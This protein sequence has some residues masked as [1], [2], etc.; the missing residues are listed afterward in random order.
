MT[1]IGSPSRLNEVD[2]SPAPTPASDR[3]Y[4][5]VLRP[6]LELFDAKVSINHWQLRDCIKPCSTAKSSL[7][8]IH[9]HSIRSLNTDPA[10][11][12][13]IPAGSSPIHSSATPSIGGRTRVSKYAHGCL[14]H[15]QFKVA[16][17]EETLGDP[18]RCVAEFNFKPRCFAEHNGLFACG[19]LVGSD[20]RG[21]PT[22][23]N[24]YSAVPGGAPSTEPPAQPI[25]MESRELLADD[26]NYSNP[27]IWKGILSLYNANTGFK[28]SLVL[29]QFINNCVT[30]HP[31]SAHA[32]NLY[33]CNNDGHIYQCDVSNRDVALVKRYSDLKFPLNNACLS[34]DGK[35]LIVSGDSNKFAIYRQNEVVNQFSLNYDNQPEWGGGSSGRRG[36]VR[37]VTRFDTD[38]STAR[39][40][41]NVFESSNGDHGFYSAFSQN[42]QQFATLFQNGVCL[43]YDIRNTTNPLAEIASSRAQSHNG[44]F[45]VCKFSH[46]VDDLLIISEHQGR[47]HVVDTRN[48]ANH[49]VIFLPNKVVKEP[50][51]P[52]T[53]SPSRPP[54][55]NT[56]NSISRPRG[57]YFYMMDDPLTTPGPPP[58]QSTRNITRPFSNSSRS[59][60]NNQYDYA[61]GDPYITI[62]RRV[63]MKYLQPRVLPYP[64][65]V[66]K[67]SNHFL[68]HPH[69]RNRQ[70]GSVSSVD[71]TA[72]DQNSNSASTTS[73]TKEEENEF[74]SEPYEVRRIS[75]SS[76]IGDNTP[77]MTSGVDS[78][79]TRAQSAWEREVSSRPSSQPF[80]LEE[81][82]SDDDE[83]DDTYAQLSEVGQRLDPTNIVEN[84]LPSTFRPFRTAH[85]RGNTNEILGRHTNNCL[86]EENNISG[87]SW[88]NDSE[89]SSLIVGTDY[90][91]MKWN[92]DTYSRRS[93]ASFDF[94]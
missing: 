82:L 31:R 57:S 85:F 4:Q 29:G 9:D 23:W 83:F 55:V 58:G 69:H 38:D 71:L 45:R 61:R 47:V 72:V 33:A 37:I 49:Q 67:L 43:M 17:T 35:T 6:R 75:T 39:L 22:N 88:M 42:D 36:S 63:P 65:A 32:Y 3:Q 68:N 16:R 15:R 90:G 30:M 19:G 21:F 27:A 87:L 70:T 34:N 41:R 12:N 14:A 77:L 66:N 25:Y 51:L 10:L 56:S 80:R 8:Y 24:R 92:I 5:D 26:T 89:G 62:S 46:G 2:G 93:F 94:C 28:T 59:S 13:V 74:L 73:Q 84:R 60:S 64:K 91:I 86:T 11:F 78:D 48:F 7:Y 53:T 40:D 54:A 1:I 81:F 50:L 44:A 20:D 76:D 52:Q 79:I 18:S